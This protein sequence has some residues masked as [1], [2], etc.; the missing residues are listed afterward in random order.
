MMN[1]TNVRMTEDMLVRILLVLI[2]LLWVSQGLTNFA[3][4][5]R[6]EE[7]SWLVQESEHF[8]ITYPAKNATLA[9]KSL[10]IAERVH[11]EL[12]PFF[13]GS[14]PKKTQ[15]VL[16]DDFDVSNGWA[17]FFPFAQIRLYTSPPDSVSGL[18][19]SDDWL[20]T[21]IRHEYVHVLHMEM[22]SASPE[23]LR[24]IFG[25]VVV[26][27]PHAITPSFMLEGLATYLETNDDLAY[28]RLQSSYYA[29][30]MRME[31]AS[32]NLKTLGQVS[33]PLREW[34]L[35]LNYLY[36][37]YFYQFLAETYSDEKIKDY[38]QKYSRQIIPAIMQNT[39]AK[40]TFGKD[41]PDLWQD[42]HGWLNTKFKRQIQGLN[43]PENISG[44]LVTRGNRTAYQRN[45]E[46]LFKDVSA[47]QGSDFYY[48]K[49]D[50]EDTP[51][52]M[53]S[54][55]DATTD[56]PKSIAETKDVIAL[57]INQQ[58]DI[59]SS[60]LVYWADGRNW[61]D[62]YL[63]NDGEWQALTHK[64]RFRNVRWLNNQWMIA[65]R[66]QVG[67]SEL[68]L[69]NTTGEQ[70]LLWQGRNEKTVLG[71][72]DIS[73]DGKYI[74]AAVKRS[75]QGWNLEKLELPTAKLEMSEPLLW[76]TITKTTAVETSPQILADGRILFSADYND[77]YNLYVLDPKTK[78]LQ[79][80]TDMLGGAFS[81]SLVLSNEKGDADR[82]VFQAYTHK[83][84][85]FREIDFN[86]TSQN[87]NVENTQ[88]NLRLYTFEG[89][90]NYP[91]PFDVDVE[92]SMPKEY[93]PWS[94]LTP[95]WW[96][97][98]Y[99]ATP[100]YTQLGLM[101]SGTDAL[102]RHLYS[103]QLAV[104]FKYELADMDVSY[105]YDNRYQLAFNR[106]HDYIDVAIH[107]E[108]DKEIDY[109][110]EQDQWLFSRL[111]IVNG[112]EDQ[113]SL[114]AAVIV[115][116]EGSIDRDALFSPS[117]FDGNFVLHR[118]CEKSLVG[119]GLRFDSRDNYLNSPGFS[120]GRY[121]DVVIESNEVLASD[122]EGEVIQAQWIEIF[123]LPGR[124]SLSLQTLWGM[125]DKRGEKFTLGGED[126]IAE[127]AL[128][129]RDDFALRGYAPSS[130]GGQYYNINRINV[131]QWLARIEQGWGNYPIALG[132]ISAKA[133]MDYGSAWQEST[134]AEYVAGAGLEV[135]VEV[136]AFYNMLVPVSFTYA[137]GFDDVRGEDRFTFGI[138]LPY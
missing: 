133:F 65:S 110:V 12:L 75:N 106:T 33:A 68:V 135:N 70:Q 78:D 79:Q 47:S 95:T 23:F 61:A 92:K 119:L 17:T 3:A 29:M 52:L 63:L 48:I 112:F 67:I 49:N 72:Y 40:T 118:T 126:R 19:E 14:P 42:F 51:Q 28:G 37:S 108:R 36:G 62:L 58:G 74:V 56:T 11:H 1:A 115:Q 21:L 81:P 84:F 71:N 27:F 20:H 88:E 117:C 64:Q 16:V 94:T 137:H 132:D 41:F 34:P 45:T 123:D 128:F 93:Q 103:A 22:G 30:Q 4:W 100:E 26:L 2:P 44:N 104:D 10:N 15:M 127:T 25:R 91:D 114:N 130:F 101:T 9:N 80:L 24:N 120:S 113:L 131:T 121:L 83:G 116:R 77:V 109:I 138:S 31:V 18:E 39:I 125:T 73:D 69:L 122:Y 57:D 50:G 43:T 55:K 7:G 5:D 59:V 35:G 46:A 13:G 111:N 107:G 6:E 32:G 38:L 87:K 85:E 134:D 76:K 54:R 124:R 105:T 102:A 82:I 89:Q 60:R 136:F 129:G 99:Q 97:P 98:Y 66:K 53:V 8:V 96:L 90:L 86:P